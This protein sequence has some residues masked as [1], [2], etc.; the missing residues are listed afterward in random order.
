MSALR[1]HAGRTTWSCAAAWVSRWS[2]HG[3]A[4]QFIV[5]LERRGATD[6]HRRE[7]AGLGDAP[8]GAARAG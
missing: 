4:G 1:E 6:G 2:A 7:A 5:C 3:K 8:A